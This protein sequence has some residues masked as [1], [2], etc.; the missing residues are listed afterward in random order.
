M[1]CLDFASF[2]SHV[3]SIFH[4]NCC[5]HVIIS[6]VSACNTLSQAMATATVG[7]STPPLSKPR[8]PMST[9]DTEEVLSV[10]C[11]WFRYIPPCHFYPM[12]TTAVPRISKPGGTATSRLRLLVS[13]PYSVLTLRQTFMARKFISEACSQKD[14]CGPSTGLANAVAVRTEYVEPQGAG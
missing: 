10:Y 12:H 5:I 8:R 13:L 11:S 6:D 2:R 7:L 3:F 14:G 1:A 4:A 9:A